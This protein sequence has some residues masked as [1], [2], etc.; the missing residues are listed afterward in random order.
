[1]LPI[2]LYSIC[3]EFSNEIAGNLKMNL[4]LTLGYSRNLITIKEE[5]H[6]ARLFSYPG[7]R[8]YNFFLAYI[9]IEVT[10]LKARSVVYSRKIDV[11]CVL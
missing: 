6:K 11:I 1:M 8:N 3:L 10:F 9:A 4:H 5:M 2:C 7:N